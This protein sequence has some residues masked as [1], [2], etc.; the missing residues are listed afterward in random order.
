M[1]PGLARPSGP[2]GPF[3]AAWRR[4]RQQQRSRGDAGG[5]L[6]FVLPY[7]NVTGWLVADG[8]ATWASLPATWAG[9][10]E[11]NK[12]PRSPIS[13]IRTV[14]VGFKTKFV[15]LVTVL[16]DGAQVIE[17]QHSDD[18][19]AYSAY[20]VVGPQ[21][22]AR[23]VRFRVTVSGA[24][25]K[26]KTMRIILSAT[27]ITEII[28]NQNSASLAGAYRIGV[29]DVRMPI[30]KVYSSIKK[31]DVMLQS[32]GAGWSVELLDK[33]VTVGPHI[34]IY[35]SSNALADAVFDATVTGI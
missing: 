22:D 17:E 32:V 28:E 33:D 11:W 18:G 25:P 2:T 20:A 10:A 16:A 13:Y 1:P 3:A 26:V 9:W 19:L 21:V 30:V 7:T 29:G 31:V 6:Y 35:N 12:T 27:P 34:K 14:D 5:D 24:Y 4:A 8:F 23:F 15:P